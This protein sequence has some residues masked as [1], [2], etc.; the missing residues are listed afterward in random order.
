MQRAWDFLGMLLERGVGQV[1]MLRMGLD[2]GAPPLDE[3]LRLQSQHP[4]EPLAAFCWNDSAAYTLLRACLER[5]VRVPEQLAVAG[6][7]GFVDRKLPA[8]RLTTVSCPL[9]EVAARAV[10]ILLR[11]IGGEK[12]PPQTLLPPVLVEGNTA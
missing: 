12:V 3:L 5:G 1:P 10:E 11:R 9:G 4:S 2:T 7:D 8:L 6:F